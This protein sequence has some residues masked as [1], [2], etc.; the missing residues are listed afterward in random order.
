MTFRDAI[1]RATVAP[2]EEKVLCLLDHLVSSATGC[3]HTGLPGPVFE[4][5]DG[6]VMEYP[7]WEQWDAAIDRGWLEVR[8]AGEDGAFAGITWAGTKALNLWHRKGGRSG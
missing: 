7:S 3:F 1:R 6:R 4:L 5:R 2:A 8:D